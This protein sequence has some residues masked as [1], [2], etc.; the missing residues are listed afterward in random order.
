M[1]TWQAIVKVMDLGAE[2]RI[3]VCGYEAVPVYLRESLAVWI[4]RIHDEC[5]RQKPTT[6]TTST[7]VL[8]FTRIGESGAEWEIL[9]S[10]SDA[11]IAICSC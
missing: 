2:C 11:G 6:I 9:P 4:A 1:D 7:G 5:S 3:E 8:V 10:G